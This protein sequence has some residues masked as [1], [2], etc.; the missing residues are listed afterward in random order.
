M[1]LWGL[2]FSNGIRFAVGECDRRV[3]LVGFIL[4]GRT[5]SRGRVGL[6][7][8]LDD[9]LFRVV[10][11]RMMLREI[12]VRDRHGLG[13]RIRS[14]SNFVGDIRLLVALLGVDLHVH[15]TVLSKGKGE[16][17]G[18]RVGD[19]GVLVQISIVRFGNNVGEYLEDIFQRRSVNCCLIVALI[20]PLGVLI[21]FPANAFTAE[22]I[23]WII[24]ALCN[25]NLAC[26]IGIARQVIQESVARGNVDRR[27]VVNA[28]QVCRPRTAPAAFYASIA[29]DVVITW[30]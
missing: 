29:R 22:Y 14:D 11:L 26:I 8:D 13:L 25:S 18:Q 28:K 4:V 30:Q 6:H 3:V 1:C 21:N 27:K 15:L 12:I 16:V 17:V 5:P 19:H 20:C 7:L 2:S 23:P 10:A 9:Q 24:F